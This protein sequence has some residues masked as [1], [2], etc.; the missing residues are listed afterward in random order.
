MHVRSSASEVK[1]VAPP[2]SSAGLTAVGIF[3]CF[4]ATMAG[5]A[6]TTLLWHGTVLDCAWN[7]NPTAYRQL[8]PLGPPAGILFLLLSA[9][10]A[11]AAIGWFKR[12]NW[13]W[14]LAVAIISV[15]FV[16]DLVNTIRGD[17]VKGGIGAAI[18]GALLF[19]LLRPNVR[20]AFASRAQLNPG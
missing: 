7:L 5:L 13:G 10:L 15:Q 8:A 18:A 9:A 17:F 2:K 11:A 19:Y 16:G 6:G 3:L 20:M 14:R 12:R 1:T 4:G